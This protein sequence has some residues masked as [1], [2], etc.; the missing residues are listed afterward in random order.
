MSLIAPTLEAFFTDRLI[1][2]R[3]ASARTVTACRDT[4]RLLLSFAR[5]R[6]GR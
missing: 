1:T 3:N 4:F 6:Q 2:Q 5:I